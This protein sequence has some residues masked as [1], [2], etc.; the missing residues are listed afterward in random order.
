MS[1]AAK[2]LLDVY[3]KASGE[4]ME[5]GSPT[6][7][8]LQAA[9]LRGRAH[10]AG[11]EAVAAYARAGCSEEWKA[12]HDVLDKADVLQCVGSW[13]LPERISKLAESSACT[14]TGLEEELRAFRACADATRLEEPDPTDAPGLLRD[15]RLWRAGARNANGRALKASQERDEARA[16]VTAL[17]G[18][19]RALTADSAARKRLAH[20][21]A[22]ACFNIGQP[23]RPITST[24]RETLAQLAKEWDALGVMP[25]SELLSE[26][27]ALRARVAG[28]EGQKPA[29][30]RHTTPLTLEATREAERL[31]R[32]MADTE[33]GPGMS[34]AD[35]LLVARWALELVVESRLLYDDTNARERDEARASIAG[36]DEQIA[37]LEQRV[38][39]VGVLRDALRERRRHVEASLSTLRKM[40]EPFLPDLRR[41][42]ASAEGANSNRQLAPGY[43]PTVGEARDLLAVLDSK[44]AD[45]S[46]EAVASMDALSREL[47][48]PPL[49][50]WA[51]GARALL[52]GVSKHTGMGTTFKEWAARLC[53]EF[54]VLSEKADENEG[55]Q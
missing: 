54:D 2:A 12:A 36:K 30:E 21:M 50:R 14:I 4:V 11:L 37:E 44:V 15:L 32:H 16:L 41:E 25:G 10:R 46:E 20:Q 34:A 47:M 48:G 8:E 33:G 28:T 19:M 31:A 18:K 13:T 55:R 24:D 51:K 23:E 42:V 29:P 17:E 45:P 7:G 5:R 39:N 22:T 35:R 1:D 43:L 9:D 6:D 53:Q 27:E 38:R 3:V 26:L 52:F 40:L 49:L